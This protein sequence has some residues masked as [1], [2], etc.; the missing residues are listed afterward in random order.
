VSEYSL[1]PAE[2]RVRGGVNFIR[3]LH[4]AD[5]RAIYKLCDTDRSGFLDDV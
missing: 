1:A 3:E 5:S 4:F 2:S